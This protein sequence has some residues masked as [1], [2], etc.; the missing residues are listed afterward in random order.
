MAYDFDRVIDRRSTESNKWHKYPADVLPLWVADMD[1]RS[2]EPVLRA[3]HERVE[4]GVFGYGMEQPEF[5]EVFLHRLRKRY[6]WR[7]PAEAT[8]VLPG[9]LPCSNPAAR[10]FTTGGDGVLP[11]T[12]MYPPIRRVPENVTLTSDELELIRQRDGRYTID[13]DRFEATIGS[14]T[15]MFLL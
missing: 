11:Q 10:A 13:F 5:S 1:F 12:P 2:P 6:G 15:R 4:H 8:L 14:R 3:L 9:V 7:V